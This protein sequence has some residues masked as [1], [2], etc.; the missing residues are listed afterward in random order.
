M[1]GNP[2][3]ISNAA[4]GPDLPAVHCPPEQRPITASTTSEPLWQEMN[5]PPPILTVHQCIPCLSSLRHAAAV[6]ASP[7]GQSGASRR[8][9]DSEVHGAEDQQA[10]LPPAVGDVMSNVNSAATMF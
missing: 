3:N 4:T 10:V 1:S 2:P 7:L 9:I 8:V 6:T 5:L